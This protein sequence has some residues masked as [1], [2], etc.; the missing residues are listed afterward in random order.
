MNLADFFALVL[1]IGG[2]SVMIF[3]VYLLV[4]TFWENR[5][6]RNKLRNPELG[7]FVRGHDKFYFDVSGVVTKLNKYTVEIRLTHGLALENPLYDTIINRNDIIKIEK[8]DL[9]FL[10]NTV[11]KLNVL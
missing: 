5:K 8:P 4:H 11:E 1:S 6:A 10:E 9:E 7:D 3:Y 2:I